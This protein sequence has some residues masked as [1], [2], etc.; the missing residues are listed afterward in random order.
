LE[1]FDYGLEDYLNTGEKA[2]YETGVDRVSYLDVD[3]QIGTNF[4]NSETTTFTIEKGVKWL[5]T[6]KSYLYTEG[7]LTK[8]DGTPYT[9]NAQD[10]TFV[11]W[12][13]FHITQIIFKLKVLPILDMQLL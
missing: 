10:I 13:L 6:S 9:R 1:S 4:N 11:N 8:T 7:R 3:P 12:Y 5:L 2:K